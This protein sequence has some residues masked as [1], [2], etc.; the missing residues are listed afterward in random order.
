MHLLL[1]NKVTMT[2]SLRLS[3]MNVIDYSQ[4][5]GGEAISRYEYEPNATFSNIFMRSQ[6]IWFEH[7]ISK[8]QSSGS[9]LQNPIKLKY[10]MSSAQICS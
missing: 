5:W 3:V 10:D 6:N 9:N 4:I 7:L 1:I 8:F 2:K